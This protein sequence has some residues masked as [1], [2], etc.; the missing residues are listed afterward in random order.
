MDVFI[1]PWEIYELCKLEELCIDKCHNI[2]NLL[3]CS[4]R[5]LARLLFTT[6]GKKL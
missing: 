5:K 1:K 4:S 6:A 3:F 2:H